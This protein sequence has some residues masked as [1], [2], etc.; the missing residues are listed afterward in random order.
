M[1]TEH[2]RTLE[3]EGV[4]QKPNKV[5]NNFLLHSKKPNSI[6]DLIA[7]KEWQKVIIRCSTHPKEVLASQKVRLYG[8]DRK[9]LP[10]HLAC[11]LKPPVE[12]VEA[13][14]AADERSLSVQ[15]PTKNFKKKFRR[16]QNRS[17]SSMNTNP[18]NKSTHSNKSMPTLHEKD[19]DSICGSIVESVRSSRTERTASL[20]PPN[21]DGDETLVISSAKNRMFF[22]DEEPDT[23]FAL[24]LTPAGTVKQIRPTGD[25]IASNKTSDSSFFFGANHS[26]QLQ[27]HGHGHDFLPLC[28]ACLFRSSSTVCQKLIETYPKSV[29]HKNSWGMQPIH[30]VCS[31]L[32]LQT[33]GIASRTTGDD[34][35]TQQFLSG[36]ATNFLGSDEGAVN[37]NV[38]GWNTSLVVQMLVK[39]FP[40][41]VSTKSENEE[42]L[43][44]IEYASN[45]FPPSE[46]R[47]IV[48]DIL[49][50]TRESCFGTGRDRPEGGDLKSVRSS[51][52][53]PL[54]YKLLKVKDWNGVQVRLSKWPE[55]AA[56]WVFEQK[57]DD[58]SSRLPI[59]LACLLRAPVEVILKLID[60]HPDGIR[61]KE[62]CG[63]YPLHLACQQNLCFSTITCLFELFPDAAVTQDE[64]GRLPIHHACVNDVSLQTIEYLLKAY[65]EIRNMKDYN[66]HTALTYVGDNESNYDDIIRLFQDE[67]EG[68]NPEEV[69]ME[70]TFLTEEVHSESGRTK[71]IKGNGYICDGVYEI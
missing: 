65:P 54:L 18:L 48:L 28:V 1:G 21:K 23:C 5:K 30:I 37:N 55:E 12:V 34:F 32:V 6:I 10:L 51:K 11:A 45:N 35:T 70:E 17:T 39:Q 29:E 41:S 61:A 22:P 63:L 66:G 40:S 60:A 27:P 46:E 68:H 64:F 47:E 71:C 25:S 2:S 19:S 20:S 56:M 3:V 62:K 31:N 36:L 49:N 14:L 43:T 67:P 50:R 44:P 16:V 53:G 58:H 4:Y 13:L 9:I 24:Q 52:N 42:W 59:H 38:N 69:E 26:S 57:S 8:V 33:P 15:T 7:N